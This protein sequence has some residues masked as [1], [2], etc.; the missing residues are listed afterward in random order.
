MALPDR[1][2]GL[3]NWG[4]TIAS[5]SCASSRNWPPS[6]L[7]ITRVDRAIAGDY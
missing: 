2:A 3:L 1:R 5:S 7:T 4:A 6:G